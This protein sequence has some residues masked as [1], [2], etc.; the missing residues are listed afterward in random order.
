MKKLFYKILIFIGLIQEPES[1]WNEKNKDIICKY[2]H[3]YCNEWNGD[4][5]M[6]LSVNENHSQYLEDEEY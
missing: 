3:N 2:S 1:L 5:G 4:C 6:C